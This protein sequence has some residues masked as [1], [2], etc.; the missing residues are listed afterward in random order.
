MTLE[1]LLW[2]K[3]DIPS[4]ANEIKH[5]FHI[6]PSAHLL[7]AILDGVEVRNDYSVDYPHT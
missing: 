6:G 2:P 1:S 3:A 4:E 5:C 7:V